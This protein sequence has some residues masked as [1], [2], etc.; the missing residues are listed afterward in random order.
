VPL[1]LKS[2]TLGCLNLFM[3]APGGLDDDH[4]ALA[5]ALADVASIAIIQD[6]AARDAAIREG[7]LQHALNSRIAIEQAKGMIAERH[8]TDMDE[9][10]S[11]LR[12]HAR[13]NNLRLTAVAE[14]LVAGSIT[15]DAITAPRP[16][17]PRT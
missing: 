17:R 15:I 7:Q 1:R 9:A 5:Q 13:N 4:I 6:Q 2:H 3:S 12:A 16:P 10:F 11:R 14:A 8:N